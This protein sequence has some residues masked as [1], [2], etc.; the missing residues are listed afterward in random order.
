MGSM[1]VGG[2]WRVGAGVGGWV[3]MKIKL[4][5]KRGEGSD[6]DLL[7]TVE[8]VTTVGDVADYLVRSDPSSEL[9][10]TTKRSAS[11]T[12]QSPVTLCVGDTTVLDPRVPVG[13][14]NLRSGSIVSIRP[15]SDVDADTATAAAA[16]VSVVAGPDTGKEFSLR[17]GTN[18][19]RSGPDVRGTPEG[20]RIAPTRTVEH[21]GFC[22]GCRSRLCERCLSC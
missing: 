9:L 17:R 15:V 12:C 8:S 6:V 22:R 20:R 14:S 16:V 10:K 4:T 21:H 3:L 11:T 7:A 2:Q 5:L 1:G 19:H 13:E 18:A